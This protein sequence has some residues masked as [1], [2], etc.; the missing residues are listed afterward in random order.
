MTGAGADPTS[1]TGDGWQAFVEGVQRRWRYFPDN[2]AQSFLEAA[3]EYIHKNKKLSL[4][5]EQ[6]LFRA[7]LGC[8]SGGSSGKIRDAI[9]AGG[10]APTPFSAEQIVPTPEYAGNGRLGTKGIP[11][12]YLSDSANTAALEARP[13]VDDPVTIGTFKPSKELNLADFRLP[14]KDGFLL[15]GV[16]R[17]NGEA[18]VT[19]LTVAATIS[20]PIRPEDAENAYRPT[21]V[22][23]EFLKISGFDGVAYLSAMKHGGV[24]YALFDANTVSCISTSAHSLEIAAPT[25]RDFPT[26]A[27]LTEWL[28]LHLLRRA[29]GI[30]DHRKRK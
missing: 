20:S 15:D 16:G 26:Q 14:Q 5:T 24:N 28:S 3:A 21:Q 19:W 6:T 2:Q 8:Q 17:E 25:L 29:D 9:F 13:F 27:A 30:I 12:L 7:R 10:E 1:F 4:G 11:V 22:L 23:A 18:D